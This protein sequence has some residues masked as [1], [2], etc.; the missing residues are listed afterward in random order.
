MLM[1]V[2][3]GKGGGPNGL[4]SLCAV[5]SPAGYLGL[6]LGSGF[7]A[8]GSVL[9]VFFADVGITFILSGGLGSELSFYGFRHFPDVS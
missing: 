5:Q 9:L 7:C 6:A 3:A 4:Q 2:Q 8:A 1:W